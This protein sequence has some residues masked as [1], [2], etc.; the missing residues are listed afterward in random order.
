MRSNV[1]Q[2]INSEMGVTVRHK[3]YIGDIGPSQLFAIDSFDINPGLDFVFP[4]LSQIAMAFTE[5]EWNGLVFTYK[6]T[7]SDLVTSTNPSLGTVIMST[8]YNSLEDIF[9]DKRSME[10]YEGTTTSKPSMSFQHFVETSPRHTAH[11]RLFTRDGPPPTGGDKRLYDIGRF[12]IA[13]Q[14]MQSTDPTATIG[15]LWASYEIKF[16]KPRFDL[17]AGLEW[18]R[19]H[20]TDL[21]TPTNMM[22]WGDATHI[23]YQGNLGCT[24]GLKPTDTGV[25][26]LTF[27]IDSS[28]KSFFISW[29][30]NTGTASAAAITSIHSVATHG[31][32]SAFYGTWENESTAV[33]QEMQFSKIV[34]IGSIPSSNDLPYIDLQVVVN[35]ATKMPSGGLIHNELMVIECN[36]DL[37]AQ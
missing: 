26:R 37:G 24:V 12:S 1:P 33:G 35:D 13:T 5:Y 27:P 30:Y 15:E 6:T 8:D 22:G 4:W 25:A 21:M 9:P 14:G 19:I 23:D 32:T 17:S 10:N 20:S 31:L 36:K 28:G 18:D 11:P 16:S 3:E 2:V 29:H 34:N 7:S